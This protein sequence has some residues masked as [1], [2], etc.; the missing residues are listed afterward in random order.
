[1]KKFFS[2][3][4]ISALLSADAQA[5]RVG[6][7]VW[8]AADGA[9]GARLQTN[10]T[11]TLSL[12]SDLDGGTA[13]NT[14]RITLPKAS[15]ATL[16]ALTRKQGTVVYDTTR[17]K[18]LVDNGASLVTVGSG[19]GT[20]GN[21]AANPGFEDGTSDWTA[22][23][24][25]TTATT[26]TLANVGS[27]L[28]AY[29]W[30]SSSAAQT[31][32]NTAVTVTAAAGLASLNGVV[33]CRFKTASGTATHTLQAY[34][35][36]ILG[37]A[38]ITSVTTGYARTTV[39]FP[40]PASGTVSLRVVSVA[41]NEPTVYIDDCYIGLA[42][43][44]NLSQI[45]QAKKLGSLEWVTTTNCG[46]SQTQ[47]TFAANYA[48]DT[49]CDDNARTA[50]GIV[51]DGTAGL[52]PAFTITNGPAGEYMVVVEGEAGPVNAGAS[53]DVIAKFRLFDGTTQY[54]NTQRQRLVH[55]SAT[56]VLVTSYMAFTFKAT[57]PLGTKTFD[58]QGSV[59]GSAS[60]TANLTVTDGFKFTVYYWPP[61][62]EIAYR[63]DQMTKSE[64]LYTGTPGLGGGASNKILRWSTQV[65][66]VGA[67]IVYAAD[68]TNGDTF[69]ITE[70]GI[71]DITL[72]ASR[73]AG[74]GNYGVSVNSAQLTTGVDTITN[75]TRR[76]YFASPAANQPGSGHWVGYLAAGT[77][78]RAHTDGN[79]VTTGS[80]A[81]A[82]IQIS[83]VNSVANMP[84]LVGSIT[85]N[86]LATIR[87]EFISFGGNAAL[88]ATCTTASCTTA[89]SSGGQTPARTSQGIYTITFATAWANKPS[90][91]C[92]GDNVGTLTCS[93]DYANSTTT[94]LQFK[95]YNQVPSLTD[96]ALHISCKAPR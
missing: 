69:T 19:S 92:I 85:S 13:S 86:A 59:S 21:L 71:Y 63:P 3:L 77:I 15:T 28:L 79:A 64:V 67:A 16:N 52:R 41:G 57:A 9:S 60:T 36:A 73:V 68:S 26:N 76:A 10:G 12:S 20:S 58:L 6:G 66:S 37:S 72:T 50:T 93:Y 95:S 5:L 62:S 83:K 40:F 27:E 8:P 88:S 82:S 87:E 43:N 70:N 7:F 31:L 61:E 29:E 32:T 17:N 22:S 23:G 80:D 34:D 38:T 53:T 47:T 25:T 18:A 56:S 89:V 65:T 78:L 84:I 33:S 35:G 51:S 90:C 75:S 11:G 81:A 30:D 2:L 42:E 46:W 94:V 49:D 39:N 91:T 96:N 44:F 74:T 14:S 24:G 1:M 48:N 45:A 54:G 55:A 4:L